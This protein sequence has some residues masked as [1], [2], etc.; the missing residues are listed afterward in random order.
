MTARF[1]MI[2]AAAASILSAQGRVHGGGA[3]PRP[4][5]GFGNVVNPSGVQPRFGV[6]NPIY[7]QPTTFGQRLSGAVSG[8]DWSVGSY[9]RQRWHGG[10]VPVPV[11]IGGGFGGG[12][13]YAGYPAPAPNVTVINAPPTSPSVIINQ[14]YVP[15]RINPV[16]R[17]VPDDTPQTS[18]TSYQAPIPQNAEGRSLKETGSTID[19]KPTIYLIAMKE[20]QVYASL[21]YWVEGDTVHYITTKHAHN[22][23]SVNL[24]DEAVS[25]QLNNERGLDFKLAK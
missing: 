22:R 6:V 9:H 20:G 13:G 2:I 17:E 14:N 10:I 11:F 23:V 18:M 5:T 19:L 3:P 8:N 1:L 7:S 21:A 15:D 12:Y 4:S 25:K 16:V 24:I